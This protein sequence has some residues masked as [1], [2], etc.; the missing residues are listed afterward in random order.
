MRFYGDNGGAGFEGLCCT[1]FDDREDLDDCE[2]L[3]RH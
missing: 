3:T 1:C 2:G